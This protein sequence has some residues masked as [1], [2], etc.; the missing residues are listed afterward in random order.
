MFYVD[1]D[2]MRN[3]GSELCDRYDGFLAFTEAI[4][5]NPSLYNSLLRLYAVLLTSD[6]T[7]EKTSL[8]HETLAQFVLHYSDC[9]AIS[10]QKGSTWESTQKAYEYLMDN[11]AQNISLHKLSSVASLSAY[12]LLRAFRERF[13][14]PPHTFQLQQRI[15]IAKRMLADAISIVQ[16]AF[17]LGFSDQSHFTKKFKG[18]VGATPRQYQMALH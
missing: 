12:H 7:L 15:N 9:R 18:F 5:R 13:G 16:V 1:I 11:V 2:L 6:D 4:V 17:E 8:V 14:L 10:S 3:I